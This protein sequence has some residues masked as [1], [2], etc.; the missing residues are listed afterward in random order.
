M[1]PHLLPAVAC[2]ILSGFATAQVSSEGPKVW[3]IVVGID[4]YDDPTIPSCRGAS[5]DARAIRRWLVETAGWDG[6]QVLGMD[7]SGPLHHGPKEQQIAALRPTRANL[8]WAVK[9]WLSYRVRPGD[10]VLIAFAGQAIGGL[11]SDPDSPD[12]LLPIDAL[13]SDPQATGWALPEAIDALASRGE[14]PLLVWLDT[15]LKGRGRAVG[16][17]VGRRT[18]G[19][20]LLMET[21]RWP[22]VSAWIAADPEPLVEPRQSPSSRRVRRDDPGGDG[23]G[24][25]AGE[26]PGGNLRGESR[27]QARRPGIPHGRRPRPRV[28]PLAQVAGIARSSSQR[29][30]SSKRP[31]RPY[32]VPWPSRPT[33]P[34]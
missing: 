7:A 6:S 17:L 32:H 5:G 9:E 23:H 18:E 24:R 15:S 19:S 29:D 21:T 28:V 16:K 33:A 25:E 12:V 10:V 14:N 11:S 30:A 34:P 27:P 20:R 4:A 13:A 8:N 2:V 31:C 22:G 3:A 26:S 1:R